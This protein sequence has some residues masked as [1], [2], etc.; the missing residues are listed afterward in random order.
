MFNIPF[1]LAAGETIVVAEH[2]KMYCSSIAK[3]LN[4][5]DGGIFTDDLDLTKYTNII[6]LFKDTLVVPT[7]LE[8]RGNIIYY[9]TAYLTYSD[10]YWQYL[11][12]T[13][14]VLDELA[15]LLPE[16]NPIRQLRQ[17]LKNNMNT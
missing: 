4:A 11:Q 6:Y 2:N 13:Q 8:S 3:Q 14:P 17:T 10:A 15:K 16:S 7:I 12:T 1:E 9:D 5:L